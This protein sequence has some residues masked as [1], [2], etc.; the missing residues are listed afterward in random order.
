[1]QGVWEPTRQLDTMVAEDESPREPG[2]QCPLCCGG[3]AGVDEG[4]G[5]QGPEALT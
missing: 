1:M 5:G 3:G 2:L 4:P